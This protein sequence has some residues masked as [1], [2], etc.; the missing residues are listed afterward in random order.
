MN[1]R[2]IDQADSPSSYY[3][4]GQLTPFSEVQFGDRAASLVLGNIREP[5]NYERF[6]EL[7]DDEAVPLTSTVREAN[8]ST[9]I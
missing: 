2:Q 3:T 9:L 1:L 7:A 6:D 4:G 5:I 8:Q